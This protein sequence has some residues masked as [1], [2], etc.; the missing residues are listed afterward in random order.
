MLLIVQDMCYGLIMIEV[1][2]IAIFDEATY[3]QLPTKLKKLGAKD[4][5]ENHTENTFYLH[6]DYQLK[7]SSAISRGKAKIAL[8]KKAIGDAAAEEVECQIMPQDTALAEKIID[9]ILPDVQK[10]P[11]SQQRH[12]FELHGVTLS[13]KYSEDW[14]FHVEL[15]KLVDDESNIP[16]ALDEINKVGSQIGV[17]PLTEAEEKAHIQHR[18]EARK[19]SSQKST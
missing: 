6:S 18:L 5:G 9:F 3:K 7:V 2:K 17:T 19:T 8:K 15:E 4:L 12:D 13:L 14:G 16:A 10:I 11:T 1:E